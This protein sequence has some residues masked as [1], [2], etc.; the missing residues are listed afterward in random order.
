MNNLVDASLLFSSKFEID[1]AME[2]RK[3]H[4]TRK[5][6]RRFDD[7]QD[8]TA[9]VGMHSFY[10]KEFTAVLDILLAQIRLDRQYQGCLQAITGCFMP[11]A[12][13]DGKPSERSLQALP[14]RPSAIRVFIC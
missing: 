1:G 2:Y 3:F 13:S 6:P 4:R 12:N 10:R 8:T 5:M 9:A 14:S 11:Y 7:N